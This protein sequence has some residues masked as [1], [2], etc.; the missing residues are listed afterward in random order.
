MARAPEVPGRPLAP[1]ELADP[2]LRA[3]RV[4]EARAAL[5]D[6]G[7][8]FEVAAAVRRDYPEAVEP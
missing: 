4:T 6:V 3:R 1:S 2:E 7:L 8:P 5:A